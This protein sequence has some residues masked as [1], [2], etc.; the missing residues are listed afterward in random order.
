MRLSM[1]YRVLAMAVLGLTPLTL[2]TKTFAQ[3]SSPSNATPN[4][5]A[6]TAEGTLEEVVVTARRKQENLQTVPM[7]VSVV[8]Q[9][10]L[11][12]NN[13]QTIEDLQYLVPSMST[14]SS[15]SRDSTLL[16]IRGQEPSE[17]S[18]I[19]AV[20]TYQNEVPIPTTIAG[21]ASGPGTLFDLSS[22][23][24]L[25]GPQGT[26]FG[27]NST[28][29][30]VLFDTARPKDGLGGSLQLT[31][32]NY[33]DR[34][35]N[36]VLNLPL[37]DDTLITRIAFAGQDRDGFTHVLT[38]PNAP[39][40]EFADDLH[41][42]AVRDTTTFR[43]SDAV[44][45][46][47]IVSFDNYW[48]HGSPNFLTE[49]TP[50][51]LASLLSRG[52]VFTDEIEQQALGP[53]TSVGAGFPL[54]SN[55]TNLS[56]ENITSAQLPY[57][58]TFRNIFGYVYAKTILVQDFLGAPI[59]LIS[60]DA[61]PNPYR[62][63]Q[64]TEEPQLLGKSFDQKLDW[65][66]G[67]FYLHNHFTYLA[68]Q[69]LYVPPI[70]ASYQDD[71]Q[72]SKAVYGQG[73]YDLSSIDPKL[74]F[75]A[76]ARYT[77]DNESSQ[78]Q[79]CPNGS[80]SAAYTD[81][82]GCSPVLPV[83]TDR[84]PNSAFTWNLALD[85]QFD[86]NTLFYVSGRRGYRAGS[87]NGGAAYATHPE[88]GPEYL[89]DVELGVKSDFTVGGVPIRIDAAG[90]HDDY[91]NVQVTQY[92]GVLPN[93]LFYTGNEGNARIWGAELEATA[94]LTKDLQVGGTFDYLNFRYTSFGPAVMPALAIAQQST[95]RPPY[96]Y[97]LNARYTLPVNQDLG[98]I[99]AS[100]TWLWQ[101]KNA[102]EL[103]SASD[104]G[105]P[106]AY[107]PAFGVLNVAADWR[108]MFGKPLD[109]SLFMSN[110]LNKVY[111]I[112]GSDLYTLAGYVTVKYGDPRLFG[113]R[114][115]YHF[116]SEG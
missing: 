112:G 15:F 32:G 65:I 17:T 59:T 31:Y 71:T 46:D 98:L 34:E 38:A 80:F 89:T 82:P 105:S 12:Q 87:F 60:V 73:T 116:G 64:F 61:A 55:G 22:V 8:S 109:L 113:L 83:P 57:N 7:V 93:L 4:S 45:N 115:R 58:L 26:L 20:V 84:A 101:A 2:C 27:R 102:L 24:V 9:Q 66:V 39:H 72:T 11:Q 50:S 36:G 96:K 18:N 10:S 43:P 77:W 42:W 85:Y 88:Y 41:F 16:S 81:N 6:G 51:G 28:G 90:Y 94:H 86:P 79:T 52:A 107:M 110:A 111:V 76:G 104:I 103:T 54:A 67:A 30:A 33:N 19:Q 1:S 99:S 69:L 62:D 70:T 100:A 13:V 114:L 74:K 63:S 91:S 92:N 25:K 40:G 47:L 75:T 29:G 14:T 5:A 3:T 23:Q 44:Q 37:V 21:V 53:R 68:E 35:Y 78:S 95:A 97:S 48:D 49:A 56:V 106:G 108:S